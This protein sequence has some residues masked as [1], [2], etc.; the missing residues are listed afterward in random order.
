MPRPE[1]PFH[2]QVKHEHPV[3]VKKQH[4]VVDAKL[5]NAPLYADLHETLQPPVE[6]VRQSPELLVELRPTDKPLK[7]R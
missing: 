6:P 5:R 7:A 2:K 4:L 1:S 3:R